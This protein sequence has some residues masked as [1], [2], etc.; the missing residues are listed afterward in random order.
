MQ[1]A[2]TELLPA[3]KTHANRAMTWTPATATTGV[4]TVTDTRVH[5]R[6]AVC[7]LPVGRGFTG[8]AFKLTKA[9]GEI[10]CVRVGERPGDVSCDCA[11]FTFG[12]GKPC[13][14]ITAVRTALDVGFMCR[15]ERE[16]VTDRAAEVEAMDAHYRGM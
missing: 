7:E 6:Y 5:V 2:F 3:T 4:L 12:R 13:K 15:D 14:H 1:P 9:D 11:G 8:R 10:Y 16:T